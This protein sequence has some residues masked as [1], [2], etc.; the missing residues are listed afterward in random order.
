MPELRVVLDSNAIHNQ[1]E[2]FLLRR[3]V[4]DFIRANSAHSDLSVTWYLPEVVRHERQYQMLQRALELLPAIQKLERLLGHNLNITE[5]I[6]T[7]RVEEAIDEQIRDFKLQ[8]L[9]LRP[10]VIDWPLMMRHAVYR[11]PPVF[12][13]R[14]REGIP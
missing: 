3:E 11:K 6:V 1:S 5:A 7:R 9:P 14:Q 10:E 12:A 8:V 4:A 2:S 13:R